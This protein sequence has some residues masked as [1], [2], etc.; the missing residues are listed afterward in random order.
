MAENKRI[1]EIKKLVN[2]ELEIVYSE[3]FALRINHPS[4]ILTSW[5]LYE[6]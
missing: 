1:D 2:R 3:N 5:W 6:L 4:K